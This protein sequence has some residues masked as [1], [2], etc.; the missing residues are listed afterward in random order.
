MHSMNDLDLWRLHLE[1]SIREA[2]NGR[3]ARRSWAAELPKKAPRFEGGLLESVR[4]RLTRR[5]GA[6]QW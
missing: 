1:E 4:A 5:K 6:T 2:E 3:L